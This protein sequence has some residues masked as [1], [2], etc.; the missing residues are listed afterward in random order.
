MIRER[1]MTPTVEGRSGDI[2]LSRH[3]D[4]RPVAEDAATPNQKT[5]KWTDLLTRKRIIGGI[6]VIVAL[7]FIFQNTSTGHFNFLFFDFKAPRWLW[8]VGVFAAGFAT[9]WLFAPRTRHS[10]T[11]DRTSPRR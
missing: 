11:R 3:Q 5:R 7:L 10:R 6:I 1:K 8:L 2:I 9:C 4:P